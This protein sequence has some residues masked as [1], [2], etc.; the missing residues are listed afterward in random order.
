MMSSSGGETPGMICSH[1]C[2]AA[3]GCIYHMQ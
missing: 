3:I 2:N 1:M